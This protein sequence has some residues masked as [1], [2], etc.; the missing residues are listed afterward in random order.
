MNRSKLEEITKAILDKSSPYSY[1]TKALEDYAKVCSDLGGITASPAF[2]AWASDSYLPQGLAICSEA[3]AQ[4]TL[5]HQRSITF[6]QAVNAAISDTLANSID[7]P[8]KILYAGCGPYATLLLPLLTQFCSDEIEPY[9]LDIHQESLDSVERLLQAFE[10]TKYS[11]HLVNANACEYQHPDTLD[12]IISETMQKSLEHEPQVEITANL[13]D[14][15]KPHGIFIPQSIN[16]SLELKVVKNNSADSA[17][18]TFYP[19][20]RLIDLTPKHAVKYCAEAKNNSSNA[21]LSFYC[22]SFTLP[23]Q[24]LS[25]RHSL[26]QTTTIQAYKDYILSNGDCD[27]SL[28]RPCLE[29]SQLNGEAT[30]E[31]SYA[32]G[33][34]PKFVFLNR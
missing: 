7:Q 30:Y 24:N 31:V 16:V 20:A 10:L 3:A 1:K 9:F 26:F 29:I 27:L 5:D 13:A 32:L 34:Y 28:P 17:N 15:L 6:I 2:D 33:G 25:G 12:I 23:K 11:S 21:E 18:A 22:C 19:V 4:C 14:Q 8:I